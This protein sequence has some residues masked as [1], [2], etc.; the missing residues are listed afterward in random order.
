VEEVVPG[1]LDDRLDE[2]PGKLGDLWYEEGSEGAPCPALGLYIKMLGFV[3][4]T[5]FGEAVSIFLFCVLSINFC[6]RWGL[7]V[8]HCRPKIL[9]ILK[10]TVRARYDCRVENRWVEGRLIRV[11][12]CCPGLFE[13]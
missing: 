6:F 3:P 2:K 11:A 8:E 7:E 13:I 5:E 4:V 10:Q 12:G 9:C 1:R